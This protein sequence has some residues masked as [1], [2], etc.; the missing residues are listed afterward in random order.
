[1][2]QSLPLA[3]TSIH[4]NIGMGRFRQSTVTR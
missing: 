4:S 2:L 3:T 1:L